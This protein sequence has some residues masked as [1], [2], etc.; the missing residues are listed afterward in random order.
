MTAV[1]EG[2]YITSLPCGEL[3]ADHTYQRELDERRCKAMASTWDPRLVG[4]LDVSDRGPDAQPRYA[5]IN[6]QHRWWAAGLVDGQTHLVCNVHIG[7]DVAAEARLFNEIDAGTKKIT[8]WDRWYA[9]RAAGDQVVAAID[10]MCEAEGWVVNHNPGQ[11]HLQCCSALEWVYNR[12]IPETITHTLQL[13]GDVWPG[14]PE[15]VK[16]PVIKGVAVAVHDYADAIDTGRLADVVSAVT[17]KQLAARAHELAARGYTGSHAK[18][19][20]TAIIAAYN[21][22]TKAGLSLP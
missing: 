20:T 13:I 2:S 16:A 3:F 7:L 11:H 15:G 10:R 4:V 17:P 8:N 1:G 12:C 21:K 19:I 9:R 5:I 6:G 14:D 18:L 22:A